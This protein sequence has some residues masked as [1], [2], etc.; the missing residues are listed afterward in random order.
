MGLI[1]WLAI[2][3]SGLFFAGS[4][5]LVN[6]FPAGP[7]D[8]VSG[9][10]PVACKPEV[11]SDALLHINVDADKELMPNGSDLYGSREAIT[12]IRIKKGAAIPA[13]KVTGGA[14]KEREGTQLAEMEKMGVTLV[15]D[16]FGNPYPNYP[17]DESKDVHVGLG[18]CN[19]D[20]GEDC[21]DPLVQG[22]IF[23]PTQEGWS[24]PGVLNSEQYGCF[25]QW[26][27]VLDEECQQMEGYWWT[28]DVYVDI[29]H[30]ENPSAPGTYLYDEENLPCWSRLA[31]GGG[32]VMGDKR[33]EFWQ[34]YLDTGICPV[35]EI[36]RLTPQELVSSVYA[37]DTP[38]IINKSG[39]DTTAVT[40]APDPALVSQLKDKYIHQNKVD[41]PTTTPGVVAIGQ[42]PADAP[43]FNVFFLPASQLLFLQPIDEDKYYLYIELSDQIV[44]DGSTLQLGSFQ[45]QVAVFGYE[46]W[47]PAC[48]PAI[49]LYP[50]EPTNLNIKVVP[51]GYLTKTIPSYPSSGWNV[52]ANPSGKIQSQGKDYSYLFYE[53]NIKRIKVPTQGWV[54]KSSELNKLFTDILPKLGLNK[55]EAQDFTDYWVSKLLFHSL[56]TNSPYYYVGLLDRE[57][58]DKIEEI[59]FSQNPDNFI[60]LRFVFEALPG[61][62]SV[63]PPTLPTLPD[64]TGFTAVD[65]GGILL[66]GNC[67]EGIAKDIESK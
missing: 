5:G 12:W 9:I 10:N 51:E 7:Q 26:P 29:S 8:A 39:I 47:T 27:R 52:L 23:V 11:E 56:P 33:R 21:S 57:Q 62:Q 14:G 53:A 6:L 46:W 17:Y 25:I 35:D 4:A 60:R 49:Y 64:R 42:Y 31:C 1:P 32:D 67:E 37:L 65:W 15:Q 19:G 55:A 2:V 61:P 22:A 38:S 48:K 43:E 3:L 63:Q 41:D 40:P 54:V 50:Q 13:W 59:Q 66:N 44:P 58:L 18:H 34:E 45:P 20:P 30:F 16:S 28:F 24:D 36:S